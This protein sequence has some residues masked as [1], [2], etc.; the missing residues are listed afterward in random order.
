MSYATSST[1]QRPNTSA[2]AACRVRRRKCSEKCM[3]APYFPPDDIDK[4]LLDLPPEKRNDG[5]RSMVYEANERARDPVFGCAGVIN[6]LQN[7]VSELQSQLASEQAEGAWISQQNANLLNIISGYHEA[8][9][10]NYY[11][12]SLEE[13][14]YCSLVLDDVDPLQLWEPL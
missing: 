12:P 3:L 11:I 14:G 6:D 9:E 8:W 2:C 10:R 13:S 4:F 5:V 7:R 1:S